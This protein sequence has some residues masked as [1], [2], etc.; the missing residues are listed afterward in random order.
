MLLETFANVSLRA[1]R[2]NDEGF[3]LVK[4]KT[5]CL[6]TTIFKCQ[7]NESQ[8]KRILLYHNCS[9]ESITKTMNDNRTFIS[10]NA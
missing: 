6:G 2:F 3:L 9:F 10:N 7:I 5:L 1:A 4:S 8:I